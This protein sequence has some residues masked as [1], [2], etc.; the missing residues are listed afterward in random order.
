MLMDRGYRIAR[1]TVA[2]YRAE[3]RILP[4]TVR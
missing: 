2:K 3:L 1:R 4:S